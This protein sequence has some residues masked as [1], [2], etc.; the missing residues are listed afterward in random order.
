MSGMGST[1]QLTNSTVVA[2]FRSALIHQGIVA[3]L[4][5]PAGHALGQRSGMGAGRAAT[6]PVAGPLAAEPKGRRVIRIGFGVLWIID[7]LLQAQ[8]AMPLGLAGRGLAGAARP[9]RRDF[10]PA[11]RGSDPGRRAVRRL[12]GADRPGRPAVGVGTRLRDRYL[13]PVPGDQRRHPRR[14]VRVSGVL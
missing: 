1:L 14:F 5:F 8:P 9:A 13:E 10:G 6:R 7:G 2:A 4:I 11:R 12:P 3:L